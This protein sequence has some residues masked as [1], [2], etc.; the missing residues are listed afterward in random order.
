M[1]KID[2]T[3]ILLRHGPFSPSREYFE[4]LPEAVIDQFNREMFTNSWRQNVIGNIM[5]SFQICTPGSI[6]V[7]KEHLENILLKYYEQQS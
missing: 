5:F 7:M 6:D 1:S 4:S 2:K 3:Y